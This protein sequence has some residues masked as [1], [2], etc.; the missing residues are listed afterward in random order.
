MESQHPYLYSAERS[1]IFLSIYYSSQSTSSRNPS[2]REL[3]MLKSGK[4]LSGWSGWEC[5]GI[6]KHVLE[7]TTQWVIP[8][9]I[10]L[11]LAL[12]AIDLKIQL[13]KMHLMT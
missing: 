9:E 1:G 13:L 3:K 2:V 12:V 7:F 11:S 8:A 5:C 6:A 4:S 10:F